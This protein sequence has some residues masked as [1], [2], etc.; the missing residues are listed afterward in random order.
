MS[1]L[2]MFKALSY[3]LRQSGDIMS[4]SVKEV[5]HV[6]LLAFTKLQRLVYRFDIFIGIQLYTSLIYNKLAF[7]IIFNDSIC[8]INN[9]SSFHN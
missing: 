6:V 4:S 3:S 9:H 7:N 5:F 1:C 2:I 8:S